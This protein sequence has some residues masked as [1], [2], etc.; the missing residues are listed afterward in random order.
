MSPSAIRKAIVG[1]TIIGAAP[2]TS[3]EGEG[4]HRTQMHDWTI[5]LDNGRMLRFLVEEHPDGAD[6][7]VDIVLVRM[8]PQRS[9]QGKQP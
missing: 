4:I 5:T 8:R 2:N 7:G 1:R 9:K 6:H 3:W